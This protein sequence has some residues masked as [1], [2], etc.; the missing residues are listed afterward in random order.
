[1]DNN[2]KYYVFLDDLKESG[3][4]N[5]FGARPYLA[6]EFPELSKEESSKILS[7]WMDTFD[8]RHPD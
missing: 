4:V 7:N 8:E 6:Q 5:M 1:M 2:E 3:Q